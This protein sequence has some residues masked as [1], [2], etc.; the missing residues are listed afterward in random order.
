VC[1]IPTSPLSSEFFLTSNPSE[2]MVVSIE[3]H[4]LR[5]ILPALQPSGG[6]F[7][8]RAPLHLAGVRPPRVLEEVP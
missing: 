1:L 3:R 2:R 8:D 6:T 5:S 7:G 4:G